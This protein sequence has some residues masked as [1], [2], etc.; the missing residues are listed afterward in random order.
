MLPTLMQY[1]SLHPCHTIK[2][3]YQVSTSCWQVLRRVMFEVVALN[4]DSDS[5]APRLLS[6]EMRRK[7]NKIMIMKM[8]ISDG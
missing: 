8:H 6:S 4:G 3:S 1:L 7:V 2:N 5:I